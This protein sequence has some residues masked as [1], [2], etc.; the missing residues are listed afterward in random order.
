MVKV[1]ERPAARPGTA[2]H[3]ASIQ[4]KL[5]MA[6]S[7]AVMFLFLVAHMVGNLKVFLGPE[8]IDV[9][10]AWLRTV[11][12]PAVPAGT[13]LWLT[14][15]GLLAAVLGHMVSAVILTRR[16]RR[17]RGRY[18]HRRPVHGGYAART[19]RWGGV[20]IALFLV[21]HILDLT[22]G[23]LNPHGAHGEV[24]ANLVADFAPD[25]WYVTV[26]YVLAVLAV[27]VHVWHGVWSALQSVGASTARTQRSL[28]IAAAAVAT[29]LTVGFLSVPLAVTT[30]LVR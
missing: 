4:L 25:R 15:I 20:I 12:E 27:G 24:H 9:Y 7:G 21:Y 8:A 3:V 1:A 2:R 13:V 22:T 26:F 28:K 5:V 19:M 17:A 10:A 16:A 23:T 29:T 6:A 14:R 18:A 11:G 30:G